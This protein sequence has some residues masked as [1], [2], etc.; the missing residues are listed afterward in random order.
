MTSANSRKHLKMFNQTCPDTW[1]LM[2]INIR[3][4]KG[5]NLT[6]LHSI[7]NFL[8][9]V[10]WSIVPPNF[11]HFYILS[12]HIQSIT[13]QLAQGLYTMSLED[14]VGRDSGEF[15]V[16]SDST[17]HWHSSRFDEWITVKWDFKHQNLESVAASVPPFAEYQSTIRVLSVCLHMLA[18]I[19][20]C[21]SKRWQ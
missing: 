20:I 14:M 9:Y 11:W 16:T 2:I 18:V 21:A 5:Q 4:T 10:L 15:G 7:H 12:S 8:I 17:D 1:G 19:F 6:S 3:P 13:Y